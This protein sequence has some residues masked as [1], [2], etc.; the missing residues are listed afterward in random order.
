MKEKSVIR[1]K[2]VKKKFI[3]AKRRKKSFATQNFSLKVQSL[4]S[5]K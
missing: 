5:K 3:K 2:K 4:I 1:K